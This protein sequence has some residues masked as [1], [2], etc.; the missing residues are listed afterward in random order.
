[1]ATDKL[2]S[3]N[4][5][6]QREVS[7]VDVKNERA[8]KRFSCSISFMLCIEILRT[9]LHVFDHMFIHGITMIVFLN[10]RFD[11]LVL[12]H[13]TKTFTTMQCMNSV[14]G[15]LHTLEHVGDEVI[16]REISIQ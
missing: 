9:V 16:N 15:L 14:V 1:M 4:H 3:S 10:C 2:F 7:S 12:D 5:Y 8:M 13:R 11:L 6:D